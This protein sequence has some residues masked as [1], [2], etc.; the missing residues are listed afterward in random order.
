MACSYSLGHTLYRKSLQSTQL[1]ITVGETL[2]LKQQSCV[3]YLGLSQQTRLMFVRMLLLHPHLFLLICEQCR[4]TT[5]FLQWPYEE[6]QQ[7]KR[8]SVTHGQ[9]NTGT[10]RAAL[11][12]L[13]S[14]TETY[15]DTTGFIWCILI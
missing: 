15:V 13:L 6:L 14:S 5:A 12:S 8:K 10:Q 4:A 2:R 1:Y 9:N 11:L 3:K 7:D